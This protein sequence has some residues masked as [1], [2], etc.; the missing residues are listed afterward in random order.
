MDFLN[1]GIYGSIQNSD[2]FFNAVK[3]ENLNKLYNNFTKKWVTLN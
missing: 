2:S 1:N 3:S